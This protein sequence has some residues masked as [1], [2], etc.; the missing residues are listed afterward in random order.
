[1]S[2]RLAWSTLWDSVSKQNKTKQKQKQEKY[3]EVK[4]LSIFLKLF[5]NRFYWSRSRVQ[6]FQFLS[7]VPKKSHILCSR[8]QTLKSHCVH[9]HK[10]RATYCFSLNLF[11][12]LGKFPQDLSQQ[13]NA[14]NPQSHQFT[15]LRH[16]QNRLRIS[17][18]H[19]T[20][21]QLLG[22]WTAMT[23]DITVLTG[24]GS[25]TAFLTKWFY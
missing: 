2:S 10:W 23:T 4:W 7:H 16:T 18:F 13:P 24:Q 8:T 20:L 15:M 21:S 14:C 19:S 25:R 6:T 17:I 1:M 3:W 5:H 12:W 9:V 22:K 11:Q